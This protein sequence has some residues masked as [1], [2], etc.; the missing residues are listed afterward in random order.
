LFQHSAKSG[1]AGKL[2]EPKNAFDQGIVLI[3]SRVLQFTKTEDQVE[4]E[5]QKDS[6]AAINAFVG[7]STKTVTQASFEVDRG[8]EFLENDE[9][10]ERSER[11]ILEGEFGKG[12]RI[13]SEMRS[14]DL[15]RNL[16]GCRDRACDIE[17]GNT[18]FRSPD[19]A[20][21]RNVR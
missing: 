15:H 10:T 2:A 3:M 4:D 6:R 11:L 17:S 13:S 7:A 14:A 1:D 5:L 18:M 21:L 16:H 9:A 20:G 12:V 19:M 8:E